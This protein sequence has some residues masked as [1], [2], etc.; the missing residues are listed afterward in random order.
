MP[1]PEGWWAYW[2]RCEKPSAEL[3]Q[4]QEPYTEYG[5]TSTVYSDGAEDF[6]LLEREGCDPWWTVWT[7]ERV[8][9]E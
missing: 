8:V 6:M 1:L 9:S 5:V 3:L 7:V 4:I 2:K